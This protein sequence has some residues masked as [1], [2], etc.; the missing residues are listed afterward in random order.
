[1]FMYVLAGLKRVS[2]SIIQKKIARV[3]ERV[4]DHCQF[5][6]LLAA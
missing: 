6:A 1:M 3:E 4:Y 5:E 2:V